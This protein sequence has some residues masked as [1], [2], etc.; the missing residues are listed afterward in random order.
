VVRDW[1][2]DHLEKLLLRVDR[3]DRKPV[4]ELNHETSKSLECTWNAN[5]W[6]DFDEDPLSSVDIDLELAS[7]I[8]GRIKEGKKAL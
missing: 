7:L 6:A 4:E 1:V 3:S 8:D 5:G 2:L